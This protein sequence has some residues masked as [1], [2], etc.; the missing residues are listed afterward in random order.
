MAD[1]P[2]LFSA[3]MVRALLA[4]RKTQ[5]RRILKPQPQTFKVV[6]DGVEQECEVAIAHLAGDRR[7]RLRVGCAIT[8]Q[9]IPY[10]KGDRLW[11]RETHALVPA[12]AYRHSHGV[13][14]TVNPADT[15][16]AAIYREG[17]DRSSGGIRWRPSIFLHRWASRLTLIVTDVRLQ[18]L[19]D[20]TEADAV[21]E[22]IEWVTRTSSGEFYRNYQNPGCPMMPYGSFRSLWEHLNGTEAWAA[23][24]WVAAVT[25]TVHY[26][27]IDKL[28]LAA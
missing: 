21:A 13:Q 10:A 15:Y 8:V 2:I 14:H 23:N 4:G 16:E 1:I 3:P 28:E 12:T 9:E 25:F 11:V 5:T 24:P 19:Q 17:F 22:G 27:N 26:A 7:P 18:R 6:E 20:I